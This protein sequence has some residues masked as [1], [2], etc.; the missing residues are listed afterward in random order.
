M[1]TI[2]V[3]GGRDYADRE[4]A[5]ATLDR[6]HQEQRVT[7]VIHGGATGAD[8]LGLAWAHARR[9]A[10]DSYP[11]QW[12]AHGKAAGPLRNQQMLEQGRPDLVVAFP[13][14]AGTADMV[15]RATAAGVRVLQIMRNQAGKL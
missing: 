4:F 14:G 2:L 3:C 8:S 5:F 6:I 7:R 13:G 1:S 9:V 15:R 10:V 11:A 12:N